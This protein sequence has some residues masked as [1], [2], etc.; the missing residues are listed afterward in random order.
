MRRMPPPWDEEEHR[1]M[2]DFIKFYR[3]TSIY[4]AIV[5]TLLLIVFVISEVL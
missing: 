1:E 5:V 3:L 2:W 4:S